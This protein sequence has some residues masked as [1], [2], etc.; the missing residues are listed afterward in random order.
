MN[1]RMEKKGMVPP[2]FHEHMDEYFEVLSGEMKFTIDGRSVVRKAG[3]AIMVPKGVRH[4][5]RNISNEAVELKVTYKPCADTHRLFEMLVTM[6]D[7]RPF[8]AA[9]LFKVFY[10]TPRL[11]LREFST[12]AAPPFVMALLNGIVTGLGKLNGWDKWVEQFNRKN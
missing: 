9:N 4:S 8:T 12:P 6:D 1:Y 5:I 2:H 3:E 10:I 7:S 11:G